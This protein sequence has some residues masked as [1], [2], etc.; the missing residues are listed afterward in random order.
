MSLRSLFHLLMLAAIWGGSFLFTR[1]AVPALGPVWLIG[2]RVVL[3]ALFLLAVGV[4]TRRALQVKGFFVY[5]LMLGLLNSA[6]PF[7]LFAFSAQTLSASLLSILN[8]TTPIFG[9]VIQALWTRTAPTLKTVLGLLL[10]LSGVAVLVGLDATHLNHQSL[11]AVAAGLCGALCYAVASVYARHARRTP[12]PLSNAHGGMW[13][14]ALLVVPFMPF[15]VPQAAQIALISPWVIIG[16]LTLGVICSGLAYIYYFKLIDDIGPAS[17]LT[18]TFLIPVFGTL[19]GVLFLNETVGWPTVIGGAL[20]LFGTALVVN[21]SVKAL[22]R[23][24]V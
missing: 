12:S 22:F 6:V 9:V 24:K 4:L 17:A 19:W 8:S 23:P 18:V 16:V 14:S 10:G 15:F 21:L 1:I 11:I 3:A 5:Y 13:T 20:I 7:L 2:I